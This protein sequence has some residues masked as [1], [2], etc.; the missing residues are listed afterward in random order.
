MRILEEVTKDIRMYFVV[1]EENDNQIFIFDAKE[2]LTPSI[3]D[4][5]GF[6]E[7]SEK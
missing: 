6:E 3:Y 2:K 4:I 5:G 7:S 1:A